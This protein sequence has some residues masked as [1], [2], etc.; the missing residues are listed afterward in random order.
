MSSE[1]ENA[2]IEGVPSELDYFENTAFQTAIVSEYDQ[3]INPT[4]NVTDGG[5][6]EFVIKGAKLI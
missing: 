6:I 2:P 3:E 1:G 5:P 4:G